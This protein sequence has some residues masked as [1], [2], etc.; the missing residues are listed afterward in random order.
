MAEI[1]TYRQFGAVGD[2]IT[3][4]AAAI[5]RAHEEANRTGATVLGEKGAV[6]YIG[7][8]Q[9]TI[10]VRTSVDWRGAKLIFDDS[11]IRYDDKEHRSVWVFTVLPDT[12]SVKIDVPAGMSLAKGQPNIGIRFPKACML[13]LEDETY[14]INRRF[15]VNQ[16]SGAIRHEYI[17]VDENGNVDP[18]TPIQYNYGCVTAITVYASDDAPLSMGNGYI[19]TV[20]PD[21]KKDDPDYDNQYYY[22]ARGICV[23]RSN[24]T[25]H[26]IDHTK[27]GED[28]AYLIDR[29][30][31]GKIEIYGADKPFGVPYSGFF[32]FQFCTSGLM[33][34]CLIQ[35]H[36]AYNFFMPNGAR[37]ECGSYELLATG[38]I[39]LTYRNLRQKENP[40]TG[41]VITNR[42]MYHGT[43][44]SNYCRNVLM[45]NCYLD[46]FDSHQGLYNATIR[47]CVLGFGI[48]AI[49]GGTLRIENVTRISGTSFIHFRDDYNSIFDG[50]IIVRNCRAGE[51][52]TNLIG[53][54]W[55]SFF[56]GLPNHMSR[57]VEV[58]GLTAENPAFHIFRVRGASLDSARTDGVN[59][60][61]MPDEITV[62]HMNIRPGL[63][64]NAEQERLFSDTK[65]TIE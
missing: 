36:Q 5:R 15:G 48:L 51:G 63:A 42:T 46:R 65:V 62:R 64:Q 50:D 38:C 1:I 19:E 44:G 13:K 43:M 57:R 55:R 18:A 61:L 7:V 54:G 33:R 31:D 10:P 6:Y 11:R 41:E 23:R 34:D 9:E 22:F 17:L 52:I 47:D 12:D 24:V 16:N 21:P 60:L 29:N 53:A 32:N 4:D 40:E 20:A 56:N 27:T 39:G 45:E 25:L 30:G 8:L 28:M 26:D 49:G 37:N 3:D 59:P 14:K 2:G 35:G 58:D